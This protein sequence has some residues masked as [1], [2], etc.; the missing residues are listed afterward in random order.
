MARAPSFSCVTAFP[1]YALHSWFY[2]KIQLVSVNGS[3]RGPEI[4]IVEAFALP[5]GDPVYEVAVRGSGWQKEVQEIRAVA[6]PASDETEIQVCLSQRWLRTKTLVVWH[7]RLHS[8]GIGISS[9]IPP[10]FRH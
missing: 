9:N 1:T 4:Q 10:G 6:A 7:R 2:A 3:N 5:E 8:Q